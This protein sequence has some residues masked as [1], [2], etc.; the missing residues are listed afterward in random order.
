MDDSAHQSSEY[1]RN[2]FDLILEKWGE[3]IK[4]FE[5]QLKE[6]NKNLKILNKNSS[7]KKTEMKESGNS[8][9]G[10]KEKIN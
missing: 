4:Y 3:K 2:N 5:V 8:S 10:I 1:M 6:V 9:E 7:G